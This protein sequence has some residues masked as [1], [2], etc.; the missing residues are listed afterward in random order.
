MAGNLF[1]LYPI[2][3]ELFTNLERQ[4]TMNFTVVR[5]HREF[6]RKHHWIE[7]DGVVSKGELE[8]LVAGIPLVLAERSEPSFAGK[9]FDKNGF[10]LGHDLWRE[11]QNLKKIILSRSL[12]EIAAELVEQKPLRFGYDA[13][14]PEVSEVQN[15]NAYES[16]LQTNPTL[17]E[18]S[19]IQGVLCGAM[20]CVSGSAETSD[21]AV[22]TTLFS[23]KPGNAV[24]FS[25]EWSLPLHEIYANPGFTYLLIVYTKAN[26]VYLAQPGDP[27]LHNFKKLG[28]N[29][30]D[31]LNDGIHPI[32]Y[33]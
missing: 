7:C 27:H 4:K 31:R 18:M 29:F 15:Q 21:E 3:L 19:C 14:F 2:S 32:I 8:R 25:P 23:R 5:E 28:Y 17:Q 22:E 20:V 11:G 24:F 30:G 12:A 10:A 13:L 6:F 9:A 33:T 26:A 1:V 16:F